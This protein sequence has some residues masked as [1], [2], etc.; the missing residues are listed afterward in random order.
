M[1]SFQKIIIISRVIILIVLGFASYDCGVDF[2]YHILY[3]I[4]LQLYM[5]YIDDYLTFYLE[6]SHLAQ[7]E[8]ETIR[9]NI[10]KLLDIEEIKKLDFSSMKEHARATVK[11]AISEAT[12]T[13]GVCAIL[14]IACGII[15]SIYRYYY[16][17]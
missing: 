9:D 3:K 12:F 7:L 1:N 14:I 5:R 8:E 17:A 11:K 13:Y 2:F 15:C 4:K 6:K 16:L 10:Q